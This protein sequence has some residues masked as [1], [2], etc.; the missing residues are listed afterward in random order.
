MLSEEDNIKVARL[1]EIFP[2][3][4]KEIDD[5]EQ[6]L[7]Q[8]SN[9]AN[10]MDAPLQE[11][12]KNLFETLRSLPTGENGE[13]I[14]NNRMSVVDEQKEAKI[15][16]M[17]QRPKRVLTTLLLAASV[18]GLIACAAVIS[19]LSS[20]NKHY[21]EV[22]DNMSSKANLLQ[23]N[24]LTLQQNLNLYQDTNYQ[25]INL[26]HVPGKPE[27][28]VQLFW[29]KNTHRVYAADISLPNA[30][31]GKQYQLWAIVDGKPVNA[32]MMNTK[33]TPQ[34][35]FDFAKADA[36]AITLEKVGGSPAPTMT[37]LYVL[38]KTS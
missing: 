30:P 23:Q 10:A 22:A 18:I 33:K 29:N 4:K 5:I 19:H 14:T 3:I 25:K 37:E 32:G 35:M 31:A 8:I 13:E 27:A 17:Q 9:E 6:S 7:L 15:I 26:T 28:L 2:E 16:P 38:G 21:H 34:Q 1:S 24:T 12:K 20:A 11:I 36:F